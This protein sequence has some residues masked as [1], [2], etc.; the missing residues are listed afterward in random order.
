MRS[1]ADVLCDIPLSEHN[2]FR[3]SHRKR[4]SKRN[5]GIFS[6]M[7]TI[8]FKNTGLTTFIPLKQ[9]FPVVTPELQC[10]GGIQWNI[11]CRRNFRNICLTEVSRTKSAE[12]QHNH[13]SGK[14][15]IINFRNIC[16][17]EVSCTKR[18]Q[19]NG[20]IQWTI[21]CRN[22]RFQLQEHSN[23]YPSSFPT[24]L[25]VLALGTQRKQHNNFRVSR[26]KRLQSFP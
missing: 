22:I 14:S 12:L 9:M 3:I 19:C 16:L 26:S 18:L 17:K 5:G 25:V 24:I 10:N 23:F 4:L 2:N 15:A 8:N 13:S 1:E 11:C 6:G 20:G 7:S 21:R